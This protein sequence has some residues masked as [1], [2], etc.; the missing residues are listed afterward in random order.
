MNLRGLSDEA[1]SRAIAKALTTKLA[2]NRSNKYDLV[3]KKGIDEYRAIA[4]AV[5][6]SPLYGPIGDAICGG[7]KPQAKK[8]ANRVAKGIERAERRAD[9]DQGG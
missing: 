4:K 8:Y 6:T 5:C 3:W 9:D 1:R 7:S 2:Q